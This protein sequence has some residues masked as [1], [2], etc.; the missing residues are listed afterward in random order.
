M[1]FINRIKSIFTETKAGFFIV[2]AII[3]I[4]AVIIIKTFFFTQGVFVS[5][6][7]KKC[8]DCHIKE[9]IQ[10]AQIEEWK[11]ST[12][13]KAGVGCWECHRAEEGEPDARY[14]NG[15]WISTIVSPKDC[16]RCHQQEYEEFSGSHHARAGEI[17]GSQDNFLGEV[18][19]GAG[20]SVQGCQSCHGSIVKVLEGGKLDP[21]GWPNMGIGRLNPDGSKGTC[22]ACHSRHRFALSVARSPASCGK[23]HMGPDHP[24]KEI[25]D[26]SKHGINYYV[27]AHEMNL[28]KKD[29]ILGKDYTQAP[30]C[31]TC[32]MGGS[33]DEIRTHDVGDRISW[34]LRPEISY[35]QED[36]ER[37]RSAMKRTCLNCHASEWVDNFYVQ[38]DN[39][40]ELYNERYAKPAA[41]IMKRLR[42]RGA[43]TETPFDEEIEWVYYELWHHEGRRAR[44][45]ASM[46][47]PDYVQWHGFYEIAKHFY[48]KFLPLAKKLGAGDYVDKLLNTPEHRWTKGVKPDNLKFQE[49]AFKKWQEMR[50]ELITES[51]K[52]GATGI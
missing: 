8:I 1:R 36:W 16:G 40:V 10:T 21:S 22:A 46:M 38:F 3:I 45:G 51:K 25:F 17:L 4:F 24:Q 5:P 33:K 14:D 18:V 12:H 39:S 6:Q 47:S 30:N 2:P 13:A 42:Q 23:C 7:T 32:H 44:H 35:K 43:L 31:V 52:D 29:W 15:F 41:E 49:E 26:A 34:N 9:N 27:H 20:A 48:M 28:D 50:D 37:K 19:E 11:K